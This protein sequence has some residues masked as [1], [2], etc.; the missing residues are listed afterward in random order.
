MTDPLRPSDVL[1]CVQGIKIKSFSA[2]TSKHIDLKGRLHG[3]STPFRQKC[4]GDPLILFVQQFE[5][6]YVQKMDL[7]LDE[8]VSWQYGT[9]RTFKKKGCLP[10]SLFLNLEIVKKV[11]VFS[12]SPQ[13]VISSGTCAAG[14]I[15][16]CNRRLLYFNLQL[17]NPSVTI[18]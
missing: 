18:L 10:Q 4:W 12:I 17:A 14:K 11:A 2:E 15:D 5:C 9:F 7:P 3:A 1:K 6:L 13:C 16:S 8:G